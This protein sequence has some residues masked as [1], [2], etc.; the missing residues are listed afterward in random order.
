[1]IRSAISSCRHST[2]NAEQ[3]CPAEFEGGA[4]D[5]RHHLLGE[6]RTVD[7]QRIAPPRLGD[8]RDRP[9]IRAE[10]FRERA[11]NDPRDLGR[12]GEQHAGDLGMSDQR[13]AHGA[14]AGQQSNG[15]FRRA[16]FMQHA[17]RFGR[18]QRRLLGGLGDD[19]VA[20]RQRGARLSGEDREGKVPRA[21]AGDDAERPVRR[22]GEVVAEL[23]S[24]VAQ[25]IDR[26]ADVAQGVGQRLARF[27]AHQAG[28]VARAAFEE[29]RRAKQNRGAPRRRRIAPTRPCAGGA[30]DRI[31]NSLRAREG[32]TTD[33]IT[34]IGR[35]DDRPP[36]G[37]FARPTRHARAGGQRRAELRQPRLVAEVEARR[38]GAPAVEEIARQRDERMGRADRDQRARQ[39]RRILEERFDR[40]GGVGD[41]IDEGC[42]GAVFQE[43]A[44]EIGKQRFMRAD[45]RINPARAVEMG[46]ADHL[47]D[48]AVRPCRAGT[49]THTGRRRNS[50]P[51]AHGS[52]RGSARYAWRIAG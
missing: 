12:T 35:I 33:D 4:E 27:S 28:Q 47:F 13:R 38:I 9:A 50:R 42:V 46:G 5:V 11:L 34:I 20:R 1:M 32:D 21:D 48:T 15:L 7:D 14:V 25:K 30:G 23:R 41:A 29:R 44:H 8:Q 26:F 22:V 49:E 52:S 16:R 18:H 31:G 43:P 3:R 10:P 51:P 6:R 17:N 19:D 40:D 37:P 2:R 36:V 39:I 24:I 45:R